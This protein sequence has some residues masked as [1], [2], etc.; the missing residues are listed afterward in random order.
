[1]QPKPAHLAAQY[2]NQF[3]DESVVAAYHLRPP[4][5]S[6]K[7]AR[8]AASAGP[9]GAVLDLGCGMGEIA[10]MIRPLVARVDALD[11]SAG[12]IA[13]G[14]TL[15]GGDTPG[16]RWI[17][18]PAEDAPLTPPYDLVV[19]AASLHW[20]DWPIVL[21][22]IR[23]V[24]TPGSALAISGVGQDPVPWQGDAQRV[25]DRHTTNRDY[26]PYNLVDELI[27]R[28]LFQPLETHRS[29]PAPFLQTVED[30]VES[31][32]ARNGFSRDRMDQVSATAFDREMTEVVRPFAT[33]G[34]VQLTIFGTITFGTP[35]P[36]PA[37]PVAALHP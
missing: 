22:R 14:R 23:S 26:R 2:G 13:R 24:L 3:G 21:P 16:L 36:T 10:R 11:Q 7:I 30:Y 5:P 1:M 37:D 12:M 31:Y 33:D 19:A 35:A 4:Y 29:E 18:G 9:D 6:A 27:Q 17:I 32:H 20:M 8:L 15:P 28:D 34:M 25:I